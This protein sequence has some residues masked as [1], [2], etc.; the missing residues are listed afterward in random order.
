[1]RVLVTG[2]SGYA[3]YYAAIRMASAGHVVTGLVRNPEQPRLNVL[4]THEVAI[5]K[6]DVAEPNSYR[7][8]LERS[9]V[10]IHT[11]LDKKRPFDTDRALFAA[12]EGLPR[13]TTARRFIYTTGCSI[14][15]NLPMEVMDEQTE[16]NP[17]HP[18]AFR[19]GLER[20]ALALR[21]VGV[22]VVRPG[23][24]FGYDGYNSVSADWFE[25]AEGGD[26]VF[27]GDRERG[28]SWIH[29]GD[30]AE[31]YRLI[32]EAE[33]AVVGGEIFHLADDRR[34]RSIDVMRACVAATGARADIR[35]EGP[36]KG[37]NISTWFNQNEFITSRKA[38]ERLGWV[39]SHDGVVDSADRLYRSWK[40]A[41]AYPLAPVNA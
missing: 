35:F 11:M 25:M 12:L 39:A 20:E 18:L 4:R 33:D 24:M 23:F 3:G 1:M 19:R 21:N 5:L 8:E 37:D 40:A 41:A 10:V 22:V 38:R 34:P 13:R 2:A 26:P 15:G 36:M 29:V 30:L 17:D 27:R 32:A 31:A 9:D 14:F 28:W 16:P 6:G 7:A